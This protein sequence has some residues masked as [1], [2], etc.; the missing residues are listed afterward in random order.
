[1][2]LKLH[3]AACAERKTPTRSEK[4]GQINSNSEGE[5]KRLKAKEGATM[6]KNE[7]SGG[8]SGLHKKTSS[9]PKKADFEVSA[10]SAPA[11][12]VLHVSHNVGRPLP[13]DDFF[14]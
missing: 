14:S 6:K 9:N 7:G 12:N 2:Q 4:E 3:V 11:T 8:K 1:M 13:F 10:P 5:E